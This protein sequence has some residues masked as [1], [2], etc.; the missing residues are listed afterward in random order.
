MQYL[1]FEK[2]VAELEGKAQELKALAQADPQMDIEDEV[3]RLQGKADALLIDIYGKLTPWQK[4]Q[5]ARHPSRPHLQDYART[6][7]S[8]LTP[9]AGDRTFG[10][11]HA[12]IGGFA[13]FRGEPVMVIGQEKGF[14]TQSRL[15][16]NFGMARPEGYRK[17]IRLIAMADRFKMPVITFVDTPG[18]YPGKG[19]EER[20]QAEAIARAIEAC[21]NCGVPIVTTIVGE[22]GSGG[23]VAIATANRVIMLEHSIYSVISPEGCASILWKSADKARDAAAALRLTASDLLQLGV[24]DAIAKEPVGGAQRDAQATIAAVGEAIAEQLSLLK[25]LSPDEARADRRKKFL[26]M[27]KQHLA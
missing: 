6:L 3:A 19:A 23:G 22:G 12:I 10:E 24:I 7:F 2:G 16:R 5:I 27:G 4:C 11:D 1:D 8:E 15:Y 25:D 14:D 9:L 26:E 18:A 20:G 17:A 21:L 13:R